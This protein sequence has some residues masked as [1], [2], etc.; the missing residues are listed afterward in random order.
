[1]RYLSTRGES[2]PVSFTEA[3]A[4]GLAPDGG[5]YVPERLPDLGDKVLQWEGLTYPDL[6]FS[7]L[8][9]FATDL[10]EDMLADVVNRSYRTFTHPGVAPLQQLDEDLY[11]LELFHGPTLSF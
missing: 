4:L 2:S 7:F 8:K 10:P 9:E 5:L 3:V 1:M 11:L 6:C